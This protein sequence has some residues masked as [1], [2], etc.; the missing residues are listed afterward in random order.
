VTELGAVVLCGGAGLV[1]AQSLVFPGRRTRLRNLAEGGRRAAVV[2]IGAVCLFL[3][4]GLLEGVFRQLVQSVPA[5]YA[6]A[7][8]TLAGWTF[9]FGWVGR[10][11]ERR[12]AARRGEDTP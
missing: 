8:A 5:R 2:V 1:L 11:R 4:A 6:V 9:Y 7:G 10:A 3:V 12:E